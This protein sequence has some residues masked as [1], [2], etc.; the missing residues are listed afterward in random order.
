MAKG[1][2]VMSKEEFKILLFFCVV[3][4]YEIV[5]KMCGFAFSGQHINQ[6]QIHR[7]K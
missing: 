5:K 7:R 6:G 1:G 2:A 3:G 4:K